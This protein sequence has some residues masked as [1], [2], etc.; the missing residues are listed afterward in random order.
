[1]HTLWPRPCRQRLPDLF[2]GEAH[3]GRQ[4]SRQRITDPPQHSLGRTPAGGI[5]S[6]RVEPVFQDVEIK[7]AQLHGA[8]L[9]RSLIDLVKGKFLVPLPHIADEI[10]GQQQHVLVERR[11]LLRRRGVLPR[12]EVI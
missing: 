7:R 5:G 3:D 11:H 1:V 2:T 10:G 8:K 9:N 4:Q 12:I 6:E